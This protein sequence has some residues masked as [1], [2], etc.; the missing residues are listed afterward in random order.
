MVKVKSLRHRADKQFVGEAVARY[1]F[2][3][4]VRLRPNEETT[5]AGCL[6]ARPLPAVLCDDQMR[7]EAH[8]DIGPVSRSAHS[9]KYNRVR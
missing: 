5:I 6:T 7:A 8:N 2:G 4:V 1:L 9:M 3:R